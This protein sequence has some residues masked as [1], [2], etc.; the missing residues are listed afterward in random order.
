MH[1]TNINNLD[2]NLLVALEAL[3]ETSSVSRAA[4]QVNLSQPAMSRALERLRHMLKDPLLVRSGRGMVLTP[5][6]VAL[7]LP[8]QEALSRVRGVLAPNEF[9]PAQSTEHFRIMGMDY[10]SHVMMPKV[11]EQIYTQAP[12]VSVSLE[13]VSQSGIEALKAGEIDLG[14][15]VVEDG[16]DL[17]N[18]FHQALFD[19][20]FICVMRQH[21]PLS[22]GPMSL[23]TFCSSGHALLSI[24]GKGTGEID[25]RLADLGEKRLIQLR[26]PHFLA[27]PSV[28]SHTDL[29][30]T[31]PRKLGRLFEG[32]SLYIC[33]LPEELR[34]ADF[35]ISQIWHERFQH[36][37]A[38]KWLRSILKSVSRGI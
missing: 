27:I 15:G 23:S 13:N 14:I 35:T 21:H 37:P 30:V 33:E 34:R 11:L 24:T 25:R 20:N 6:G 10:F 18:C 9:I 3:L 31:I 17:S 2:L 29:L 16:P 4:E 32:E 36:D 38:R 26:L 22:K 7:R 12:N 5:R 8:L 28:I 19:D 1:Q